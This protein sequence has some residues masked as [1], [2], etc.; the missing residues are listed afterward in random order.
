MLI[1]VDTYIPSKGGF[2]E[3]LIWG[4]PEQIAEDLKGDFRVDFD[5]HS[6]RYR[7]NKYWNAIAYIKFGIAEWLGIPEWRESHLDRTVYNSGKEPVNI[8]DIRK[9]RYLDERK[10]IPPYLVSKLTKSELEKREKLS[11]ENKDE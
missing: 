11:K 2:M 6:S 10:I 1:E 3:T 5:K 4:I 7:G 8:I 9:I